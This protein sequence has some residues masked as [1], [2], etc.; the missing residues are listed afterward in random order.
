MAGDFD[1]P[2][3]LAPALRGVDRMH[4]VAMGG[5]LRYGAEILAAAADAGV[6]RVTHLGHDDP[7]R[8]DDDPMERDHR[9]LHR[10]IERSGLEFTHVFPGEFMGNTREWAASVRAESVVRAPF[11]GWRSALVHEDDI[12][13]VL[14][15]A[16]TAD[17]H[18][19]VTYRPTGPVPVTR[20][21]VVRALGA[22]LG[23]EVRFVELTPEQA[24]A[25]W[26]GTYPAEVVEW[27]LEMG[28]HL[29]G[30]AWVSPDVERVT[31]RPGR[32][33]EEWAVTHAD[34]FR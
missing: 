19:G 26:A 15:A 12:A 10:A 18:E 5:A 32:T 33:Y 13:A 1:R 34:E 3:G 11:G 27:F 2:A 16:L 20:R 14:A 22:A 24:R 8:G 30:N 21:E 29:D 4:L 23:R 28:N 9:V 31:G 7:S 25:H 17:G 6:R